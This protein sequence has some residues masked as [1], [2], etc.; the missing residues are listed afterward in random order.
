MVTLLMPSGAFTLMAPV[1]VSVVSPAEVRPASFTVA[2]PVA[3]ALPSVALIAGA[4]SVAPLMVMVSVLLAVE[5]PG[6]VIV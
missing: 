3:P 1:V 6:S 2:W 4:P 5:V